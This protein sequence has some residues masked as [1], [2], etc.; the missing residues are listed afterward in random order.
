MTDE[1]ISKAASTA[2]S[3]MNAIRDF[4]RSINLASSEA[5]VIQMIREYSFPAKK[6]GGIWES[7]K[8]LI[9]KWRKNYLN[10]DDKTEKEDKKE[11]IP[12]DKKTQSDRFG[13]GNQ[14]S[15]KRK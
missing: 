10:G 6:L 11:A 14:Q 5:T 4:C 2:L 1:A 8:E 9:V 12:A 7:D 3:G 15:A 13:K